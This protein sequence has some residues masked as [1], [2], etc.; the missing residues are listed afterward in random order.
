MLLHLLSLGF[1][2]D[3]DLPGA[4]SLCLPLSAVV[5]QAAAWDNSTRLSRSGAQG[6][7]LLETWL[8]SEL[9]QFS[10]Q[11]FGTGKQTETSRLSQTVLATAEEQIM[12]NMTGEAVMIPTTEQKIP[13]WYP[14]GFITVQKPSCDLS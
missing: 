5:V 3:E 13:F 2:E 11:F 12:Q 6:L 1:T 4:S 8:E 10:L 14:S 7:V 9:G